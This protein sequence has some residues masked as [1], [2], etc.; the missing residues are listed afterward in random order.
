MDLNSIRVDVQSYDISVAHLLDGTLDAFMILGG[1]PISIVSHATKNGSRLLPITGENL[2]RVQKDYQFFRPALIPG[3]TYPET[4]LAT[5][6][7]GVDAVLICRQDADEELVYE[8]TRTLFEVRKHLT[9]ETGR[10]QWVD[11]KQA[12]ATPIP[13]HPGA[14]RYYRERELFPWISTKP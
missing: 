1:I 2:A 7:I 8:L 13:L 3:G 12:S 9:A 6:T 5:H 4:P 11:L 10:P 14:A